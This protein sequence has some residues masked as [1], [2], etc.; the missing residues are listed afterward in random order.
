M[1]S[2]VFCSTYILN[3]DLDPSNQNRRVSVQ[4][5]RRRCFVIRNRKSGY[6]GMV[7]HFWYDLTN[8]PTV[9]ADYLGQGFGEFVPYQGSFREVE[10]E[11]GWIELASRYVH[12]D[13]RNATLHAA[14]Q[15][16]NS[17]AFDELV[18]DD[19]T[20]NLSVPEGTRVLQPGENIKIIFVPH[21]PG[22][23][24]LLPFRGNPENIHSF[25]REWLWPILEKEGPTPA[26]PKETTST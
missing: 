24:V 2:N 17:S 26:K 19:K 21:G 6:N 4:C 11:Y 13:L 7:I 5:R 12:G 9:R 10:S 25:P 20:T 8:R 3:K 22:H 18:V 14:R 23:K 16:A 15:W 1:A